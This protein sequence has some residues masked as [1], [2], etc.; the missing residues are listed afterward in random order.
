[1]EE[2]NQEVDYEVGA[3]KIG[4]QQLRSDMEEIQKVPGKWGR[5]KT[6]AKTSNK[7]KSKVNC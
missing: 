2:V 4:E 7:R 5:S 3:V 1:M 6:N